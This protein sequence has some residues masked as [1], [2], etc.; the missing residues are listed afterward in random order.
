M[1]GDTYVACIA[2]FGEA[3]MKT[4]ASALVALSPIIQSASTTP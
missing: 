1:A 3:A 4:I 2:P